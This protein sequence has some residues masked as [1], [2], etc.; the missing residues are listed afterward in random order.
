MDN[1]ILIGMPGAGKSTVGVL[2]AKTLGYAFL[3]TDLVIQQREGALL[4]SLVDSLGV[5]A[6]LDVE[7]DAICSVECRGTVIAPGGSAVCRERAMS[8]L[9]ALGRIVYLHLPLEELERRL[10]NISTRGIAMAPGETLADLFA[11]RAPLYRNYADL[12]VDVGRQS[13]EETVA[14]V[15]RALR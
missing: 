15:L 3:D 8:H 7:A 4:Q 6:F 5:E 12:T 9:K 1:I 2:L 13:L 10:N 14:L 11:Y